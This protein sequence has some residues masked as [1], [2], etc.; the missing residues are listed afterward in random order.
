MYHF[1]KTFFDPNHLKEQLPT[2][3]IIALGLQEMTDKL[4]KD[5]L[6]FGFDGF[7]SKYDKRA[8]FIKIVNLLFPWIIKTAL[9]K[10][11]V[12]AD[13]PLWSFNFSLNLPEHLKV[14]IFLGFSIISSPVPKDFLMISKRVYIISKEWFLVCPT[15][16]GYQCSIVAYKFKREASLLCRSFVPFHKP[17][18]KPFQLNCSN[19]NWLFPNNFST[20]IHY[21]QH[22]PH[23]CLGY[24]QFRHHNT[25]FLYNSFSHISY[26]YETRRKSETCGGRKVQHLIEK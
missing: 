18:N 25:C 4:E 3:K 26:I 5:I 10:G 9:K 1:C 7:W 23:W 21:R 13:Y 14:T 12:I 16:I 22:N 17:T 6:K 19:I 11:A 24:F 2:M 15:L 8:K 20:C